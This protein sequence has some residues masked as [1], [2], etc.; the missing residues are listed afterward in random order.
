MSAGLSAMGVY[1]LMALVLLVRP[2][3]SAGA[4]G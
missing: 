4:H 3:G 1:F 2:H